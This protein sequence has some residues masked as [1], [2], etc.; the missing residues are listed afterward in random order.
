MFEVN[1]ENLNSTISPVILTAGELD[2]DITKRLFMP[3]QLDR[4]P[5]EN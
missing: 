1:K 5:K 3:R 4:I 2:S